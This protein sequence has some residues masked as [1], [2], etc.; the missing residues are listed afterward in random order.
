M[1]LRIQA[2]LYRDDVHACVRACVRVTTYKN[3]VAVSCECSLD[4]GGE[5]AAWSVELG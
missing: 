2:A 1:R 4:L 5:R 3:V